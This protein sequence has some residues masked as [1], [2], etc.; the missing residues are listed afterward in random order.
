MPS[1]PHTQGQN[2]V[3]KHMKPD[4][5]QGLSHSRTLS[6]LLRTNLTWLMILFFLPDTLKRERRQN[7]RPDNK[8]N[9]T[10]FGNQNKSGSFATNTE[11]DQQ[12]PRQ[13]GP[14]KSRQ[15]AP[16]CLLCS[17]THNLEKCPEFKSKTLE[18]RREFVLSQGLCF[19]CFKKGHLSSGC[20][21]RMK[22]E[23][24]SKLHPT[25]L[26]GIK[27][28]KHFPNQDPK[29]K[30]EERKPDPAVATANGGENANVSMCGSSNDTGKDD[31]IT[32][33]FVPVILRHRDCPNIEVCVY[34]LLDDGSDSTF[35]KDSVAKDLGVSGTKMSLKLNTMHGQNS[36][37]VHR[38]DSLVVQ[39]FDRSESPI[40][41]PNTYSREAIPSSR[42]HIPMPEIA[43]Q[44]A[45]L[46]CIKKQISSLQRS[47][48]ISLLIGCNCPQALK[49][50]EVIPGSEDD[51]YAIKTRLGWGII[52]PT[53]MNDVASSCL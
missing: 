17:K 47:M 22:C 26:H 9:K 31:V 8:S 48:E 53:N 43:S 38:I 18:Q 34:A 12:S 24:C 25:L 28:S 32:V 52:G 27:P 21:S 4:Q 33:M 51:P 46:E 44:W 10:R 7:E 15:G 5:N 13:F 6:N 39:K 16:K 42:E 30:E 2:G 20:Q 50:Q 14:D 1:F 3:A 49:P 37:P 29:P 41:L 19:G 36:A 11:Q 45:H 23:D 35:V 40:P